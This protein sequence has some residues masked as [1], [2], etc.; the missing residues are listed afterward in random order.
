MSRRRP[1]GRPPG[2]QKPLRQ[3]I[4][5]P[6]IATVVMVVVLLGLGIWQLE[7]RGE[8]QA[9]LARIDAAEA[10]PA[11]PAP[12]APEQF[13]KI[14][15]SGRIDPTRTARY[16]SEVRPTRQGEQIGSRVI[17][18]LM[19]A[20]GLPILVDR[21][22]APEVNAVLDTPDSIFE[23]YARLRDDGGSFTPNDDVARLHFYSPNAAKIGEALGLARVAPYILVAIAEPP[24][25]GHFPLP[26][27]RLPRPPNDHLSYALT[28]F[29]L[30][31]VLSVIYALWLRKAARR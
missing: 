17:Q 24:P 22:W 4:L 11:I 31:A 26:A 21:G 10:A 27:Q 12:E 25:A 8:K 1:M 29:G 19:L 15:V 6:T 3:R 9:I 18:P 28:W 14:F 20:D 16:L 5:F 13:T 2:P 7:R 23:G 30:A